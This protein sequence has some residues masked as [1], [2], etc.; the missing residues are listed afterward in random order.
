MLNRFM[1]I[2]MLVFAPSFGSGALL[3]GSALTA[4]CGELAGAV[5]SKCCGEG[6]QCTPESCPCARPA[7]PSEQI[8]REAPAPAPQ[9]Q[10][11]DFLASHITSFVTA[12]APPIELPSIVT[13]SFAPALKRAAF[14]ATLGIRIT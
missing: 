4:S 6:C 2:L 5:H 8:P 3:Q 9:Q 7:L 10:R 14:R 13:S 12:S 11:L 1:L